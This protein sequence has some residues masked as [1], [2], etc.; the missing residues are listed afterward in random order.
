MVV[1]PVV[2][3]PPHILAGHVLCRLEPANP[4]SNYDNVRFFLGRV[5][6]TQECSS[7][8]STLNVLR[9]TKLVGRAPSTATKVGCQNTALNYLSRLM[10][11]PI[12]RSKTR[13]SVAKRFKITAR[14]K[15]LR[16][17]S[18]RRHLLS[19]KNAKRKRQLGKPAR[20]DDT[21]VAR[22]KTNLPFG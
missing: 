20:V 6:H 17:Q 14:G 8:R 9:P 5:L 12:A 19:A 13:K 15:V 22:V 4:R 10:P 2:S 1:R 21:D 18:S 11:K 16:P 7:K 3:G